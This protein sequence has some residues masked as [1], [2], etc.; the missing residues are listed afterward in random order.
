VGT[1]SARTCLNCTK[2]GL[3]RSPRVRKQAVLDPNFPRYMLI[4]SCAT[5]GK[6]FSRN[7]PFLQIARFASS[8]Q[9]IPF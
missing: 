1:Y 4:S 3:P 6:L 5:T 2:G 9:F 7:I 8:G